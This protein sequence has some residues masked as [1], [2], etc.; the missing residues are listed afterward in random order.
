MNLTQLP[1][2]AD[3]LD[4]MGLHRE[5]EILDRVLEKQAQ[6]LSYKEKPFLA[7]L[8]RIMLALKGIEANE[9]IEGK[10]LKFPTTG[11]TLVGMTKQKALTEIHKHLDAF[12]EQ[13]LVP[14]LEKRYG[15]T[16]Y[17]H[18]YRRFVEGVHSLSQMVQ[19]VFSSR[20]EQQNIRE[21]VTAIEQVRK[22]LGR[23][24]VY[25]RTRGSEGE[26]LAEQL[27]KQ[28]LNILNDMEMDV[29]QINE[30]AAKKGLKKFEQ[31]LPKINPPAHVYGRVAEAYEKNAIP[32]FAQ[33]K[34]IQGRTEEIMGDVDVLELRQAKALKTD[35][36]KKVRDR[37][38]LGRKADVLNQQYVELKAEIEVNEKIP[39]QAPTPTPEP[40]E[41]QI[42]EESPQS[43]TD[44]G[45]MRKRMPGGITPPSQLKQPEQSEQ[46]EQYQSSGNYVLPANYEHYKN[47]ANRVDAVD[48][49][50]RVLSSWFEK[51][52][53]EQRVSEKFRQTMSFSAYLQ[54]S[55]PGSQKGVVF[56]MAPRALSIIERNIKDLNAELNDQ[57]QQF[58]KER[59]AYSGE[60][61][62]LT[63]SFQEAQTSA[64]WELW[65]EHYVARLAQ[66]V[67]YAL[68]PET[69]GTK[70]SGQ[71][72]QKILSEFHKLLNYEL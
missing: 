24:I 10:D 71:A 67:Q 43:Y 61:E 58:Q 34:Q 23:L 37:E 3:Q 42:P 4:S 56:N 20:T 53:E 8:A 7:K 69:R 72:F 44:W 45:E 33:V 16:E 68:A 26:D 48:R 35:T 54:A 38:I 17:E 18:E 27:L 30:A 9:I 66:T 39:D 1:A 50:V 36:E 59:D 19:S 41:Q 55:K 40:Q 49:D 70:T 29:Q 2:I 11:T 5:A 63:D 52:K 47:V 62:R 13:F 31:L 32:A 22:M 46:S 15:G 57:L 51:Y 14:N 12:I 21:A 25:S 65:H 64:V 60:L 28:G 6:L